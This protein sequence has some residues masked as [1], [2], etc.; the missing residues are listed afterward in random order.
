MKYQS[1][2]HFMVEIVCDVEEKRC[3]PIGV[4]KIVTFLI[5]QGWYFFDGI[6]YDPLS[7]L[8]V[9]VTAVGQG[10]SFFEA[11]SFIKNAWFPMAV[12]KIG[13]CY[14]IEFKNNKNNDDYITQLFEKATSKLNYECSKHHV[15]NRC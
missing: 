6:H 2:E 15:L 1:F 12:N 5:Q 11:N 4:S 9:Y 8:S 7:L 10:F 13:N 14:K 3:L